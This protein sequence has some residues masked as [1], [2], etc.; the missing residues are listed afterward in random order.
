MVHS[1]LLPKAPAWSPGLGPGAFC[2]RGRDE[3]KFNFS[4]KLTSGLVGWAE[5]WTGNQGFGRS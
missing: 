3:W 2:Y 4:E 1:A 5:W